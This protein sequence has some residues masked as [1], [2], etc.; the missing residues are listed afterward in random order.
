MDALTLFGLFAV[1]AMLIFYAL[2]DRSQ[3]YISA[4]PAACALGFLCRPRYTA[5]PAHIARACTPDGGRESISP[6][7]RQQGKGSVLM[8][9]RL[10]GAE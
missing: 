6:A 8:A 7:D 3:W 2:E 1:T 5:R 9:F 10:P 4:F